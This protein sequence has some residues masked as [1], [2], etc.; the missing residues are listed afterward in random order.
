MSIT[1]DKLISLVDGIAVNEKFKQDAFFFCGYPTDK[2][3]EGLMKICRK[4]VDA[5]KEGEVPAEIKEAL[6]AELKATIEKGSEVE[7]VKNMHS[8]EAEIKTILENADE[9]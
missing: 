2:P 3:N 7:A 9:L 5:A 8:N 4:Y 1:K 6:V